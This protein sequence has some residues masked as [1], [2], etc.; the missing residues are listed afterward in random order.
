MALVAAACAG[1]ETTGPEVL[2]AEIDAGTLLSAEALPPPPGHPAGRSWRIRY[3]MSGV[4]GEVVVATGMVIV[5]GG[6]GPAGGWPRIGWGH[7]TRGSADTCA[8]SLEGPATVAELPSLLDAGLAV[9]APDYEGL[10]VGGA[11]PY[12]VGASEARSLFDALRAAGELEGAD[13]DPDGPV[14]LWGFSQG[15]HAVG[16]AAEL[17]P[18]LAADLDVR[19][20][21][22][23]A[24]VSDVANFAERAAA[25][26]D[27]L[28]VLATILVGQQAADPTLDLS[29]VLGP[30]A[31][32]ELDTIEGL[33][34]GE[35]NRAFGELDQRTATVT[36][37]L[38]RDL[39]WQ[40]AL[41]DDR[42]GDAPMTVPALVVQGTADHIVDPADTRALV[43]RW[44]AL[45][46]QVTEVR[47][48][49]EGHAV[50][51]SDVLVPW[52]DAVLAGDMV[53]SACQNE[54]PPEPQEDGPV[55]SR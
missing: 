40:E 11:H 49:G 3:A 55:P 21:A 29:S 48:D 35:V 50:P 24:P 45:G 46:G 41:D 34:I 47:R 9:V 53:P 38:D 52:I 1:A 22:L 28:G 6:Q 36:G 16:F 18:E 33:C 27:Q 42:L 51:V 23:A 4:S 37:A 44:C 14:V 32:S 13:I 17:A 43:G 25:R 15:G 7:P 20:V 2:G 54:S 5:P 39:R 31:V 30:S 19:G 12:L 10:G 8:P 26:H